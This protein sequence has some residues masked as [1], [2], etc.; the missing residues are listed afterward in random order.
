[1]LVVIVRRYGLMNIL[2]K[3]FKAVNLQG[4][5][6]NDRRDREGKKLVNE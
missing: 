2:Q 3:G 1:M 5:I 6:A 4:D